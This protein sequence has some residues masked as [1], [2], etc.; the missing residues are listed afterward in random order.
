MFGEKAKLRQTIDSQQKRIE[1][2]EFALCH[3]EHDLVKIDRHTS[4]EYSGGGYIDCFTTE[5]YKCRR[6]GKEIIKTDIS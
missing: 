1:D 2:L 5:K 6:C 3:G 4:F